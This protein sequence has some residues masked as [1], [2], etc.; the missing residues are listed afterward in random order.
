MK[1]I[2]D[3]EEKEVKEGT[4]VNDLYRL[5]RRT[6][7]HIVKVNDTVIRQAQYKSVT[8]NEGDNVQIKRVTSG[9]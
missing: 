7:R 6:G 5:K 1:I 4:T 3:N 8:L 9:G 2:L